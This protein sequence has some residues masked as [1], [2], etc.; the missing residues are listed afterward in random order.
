MIEISFFVFYRILVTVSVQKSDDGVR[1]LWTRTS[2]Y[3]AM[4]RANV[5]LYNNNCQELWLVQLVNADQSAGSKHQD[6]PGEFK[7]ATNDF[8]IYVVDRKI[9]ILAWNIHMERYLASYH[10]TINLY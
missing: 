10:Q 5:Q 6:R 4:A 8:Y 7:M 9:W 2:I 1:T 3:T